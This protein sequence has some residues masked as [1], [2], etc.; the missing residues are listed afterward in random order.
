RE[1]EST[2]I[3]IGEIYNDLGGKVDILVAGVG[4]G[5][6][7]SGT[8]KYLK[9][10]NATTKAVAVEP[11]ESAVL[12][13]G[14]SGAHKIQ[15]IGAGFVPALFDAS[16]IDEILP[17]AGEAA[18]S[19][20]RELRIEQGLFCGISS[21]AAYAAA[22]ELAGRAENKGLNIVAIAPDGGDRYLSVL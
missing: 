15:G 7:I 5:G 19:A 16:L 9:E 8:A 14:K 13:G 2:L 17:V 6:T 4:T 21:G 20:A 12:S 10:K 1:R 3:K 11:S 22:L 18:F